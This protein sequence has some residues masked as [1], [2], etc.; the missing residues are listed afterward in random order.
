LKSSARQGIFTYKDTA[1]NIR[2]I[3]LYAIAAAKNP[4]LPASVRPYATTPDPTIAEALGLVSDASK[5]GSLVSRIGTNNDFNRLDLTYQ[6]P[7]RNIRRFPTVRL[8]FNLNKDHHLEFVHNYQHYFSDPDGVN[9]QINVYPGTGIVVGAP[10]V[11][12]SIYRNAFSF[13]MAER[14]TI[15]N[16]SPGHSASSAS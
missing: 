1:G 7:G 15:T 6:D 5:K 11:T 8:D 16:H 13:V 4:T 3:D 9:G 2:N 10:G 14:W 12:G